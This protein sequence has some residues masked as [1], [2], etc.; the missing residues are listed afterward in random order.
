[1]KLSKQELK[2]F[3]AWNKDYPPNDWEIQR[4]KKI[5]KVQGNSNPFISDY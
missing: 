2:K 4:D 3:K 1:M 5:T